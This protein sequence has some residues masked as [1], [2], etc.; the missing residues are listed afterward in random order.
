MRHNTGKKRADSMKNY[1]LQIGTKFLIFIHS[2]RNAFMHCLWGSQKTIQYPINSLYSNNKE[3][4]E[5][6][7]QRTPS[8][9]MLLLK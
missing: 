3:K 4:Q 1:Y 5:A 6:I 8:E 2:R 7:T 9:T